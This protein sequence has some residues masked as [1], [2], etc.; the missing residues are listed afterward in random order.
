MEKFLV[1]TF[2]TVGRCSLYVRKSSELWLVHSP[3]P[4]VEVY[5][6]KTTDFTCSMCVSTFVNE[7]HYQ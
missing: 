7:L 3:E 6:K 1:V 2:P 4:L 5:L